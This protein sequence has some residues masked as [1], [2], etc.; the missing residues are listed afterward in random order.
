M[1]YNDLVKIVTRNCRTIDRTTSREP[2]YRVELPLLE[3]KQIQLY[4][5]LRKRKRIFN[6]YMVLS[7]IDQAVLILI[8]TCSPF[9]FV[10]A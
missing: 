2:F 10:S 8:F 3:N 1:F 9:Q 6:S 5:L 7:P 4:L